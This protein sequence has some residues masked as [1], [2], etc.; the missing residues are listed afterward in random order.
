MTLASTCAH[1][2]LV[3]ARPT[4]VSTTAKY[5]LGHSPRRR[6]DLQ[7]CDDGSNGPQWRDRFLHRLGKGAEAPRRDVPWQTRGVRGMHRS[8]HGEYERGLP[9]GLET[10]TVFASQSLLPRRLGRF[11]QRNCLGKRGRRWRANRST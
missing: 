9:F 2:S 5:S 1:G 11:R 7:G 8:D 3:R 4:V 6:A 10:R